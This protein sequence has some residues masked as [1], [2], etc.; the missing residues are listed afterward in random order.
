[1]Q[2]LEVTKDDHLPKLLCNA[3]VNALDNTYAN[4][5]KIQ[6]FQQALENK[7]NN[8]L[9]TSAF[10]ASSSS[11]IEKKPARPTHLNL[12]LQDLFNHNDTTEVIKPIINDTTKNGNNTELLSTPEGPHHEE[13]KDYIASFPN[14]N[15]PPAL[16][17]PKNAELLIPSSTCKINS[18]EAKVTPQDTNIPTIHWAENEMF[19]TAVVTSTVSKPSS[20]LSITSTLKDYRP[21]SKALE[22]LSKTS[23]GR[24]ATTIYKCQVCTKA[25]ATMA[26]LEEHMKLHAAEKSTISSQKD[27]TEMEVECTS[28]NKVMPNKDAL[29]THFMVSS[30]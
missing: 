13:L 3:C 23:T 12:T 11:Q 8:K 19:P 26:Y 28:C 27:N 29:R 30:A 1:M 18:T 6:K 16:I 5:K 9:T 21:P 17:S 24:Y 25:F 2:V 15:P 10:Q 4:A 22:S 20:S 14:E 7:F